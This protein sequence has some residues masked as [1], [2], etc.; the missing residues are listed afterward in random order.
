MRASVMDY[1]V[2]NLHSISKGLEKAGAEVEVVTE[3]SKLVMAECIVFPGVGAFGAA[4][5][6]L[7]PVLPRLRERISQ[8]TPTLGVCLGM[9]IMFERSEESAG[10]G[11]GVLK[12]DVRRF[13]SGRVPQMGW[14]DVAMTDDLLF[15]GVART[16]QFYFANSYICRPS[17]RIA[18]AETEYGESF[19]S[20]V[21]KGNICGVQFH[22]EKSGPPGLKVLSNFVKMAEDER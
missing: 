17:Q 21:R 3:P 9:Q 2:G 6:V 4:M 10:Q 15:E 5:K 16:A 7:G 8:G 20:A 12:G 13:K 1:G 18:V 14:N 22:P 11:I 19:P